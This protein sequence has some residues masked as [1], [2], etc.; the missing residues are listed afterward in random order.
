[1][2]RTT[3][4]RV[5]NAASAHVVNV[6]WE[7]F[8]DYIVFR[9]VLQDSGEKYAQHLS[10]MIGLFVA[11]RVLRNEPMYGIYDGAGDLVAAMTTSVPDDA[12][13]GEEYAATR[14]AVWQEIGKSARTR[15]ERCVDA[16]KPLSVPVPQ[17]H[18]NMIGVCRSYQRTGLAG[19][20]LRHVHEVSRTSPPSEGVTLTTEDPRNVPFYQYLGYEVIG[21]STISDNIQTWGFFRPNNAT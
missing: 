1:M 18:V 4:E 21:Q 12:P 16:W 9:Y 7:S 5:P 13:V 10:K 20:L 2:Q 15:Y 14:E 19:R 6:F 11:A 8:Y 17:L 3:I